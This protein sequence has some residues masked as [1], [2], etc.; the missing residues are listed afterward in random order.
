MGISLTDSGVP[1]RRVDTLQPPGELA[2]VLFDVI[3]NGTVSAVLY[4]HAQF[5]CKANLFYTL[6]VEER[7]MGI[8]G[9]QS[10]EYHVSN[11]MHFPFKIAILEAITIG[12]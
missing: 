7:L 6:F 10:L 1:C 12:I 11:Y 2:L 5:P 8:R 3:V 4:N 9:S